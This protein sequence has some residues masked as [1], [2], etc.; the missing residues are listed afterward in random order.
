MRKLNPFPFV[1]QEQREDFAALP[2][3]LLGTV[4]A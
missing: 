2:A 1:L 3:E 4:A